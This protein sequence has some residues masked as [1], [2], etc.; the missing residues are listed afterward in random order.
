MSTSAQMPGSTS[1]ASQSRLGAVARFG[2]LIGPMLSMIDSSV[3]NVA[4]PD[5]ATEFKAP[6]DQVQWVVSAYLLALGI[7]LAVTSYL[8]K[9][10]GTLRIYLFS[11]LAFV[12]T[13]AVCAIAPSVDWLIAFRALQ[14]FAGAPLVPL[15][16]GMLFDKSA[17]EK[18]PIGAALVLFLAPSLGPTLGGLLIGSGGWR[19]IF[20]INIP[21]GIFGLLTLVRVPK[22]AGPPTVP[23]T[24]FDPIGF[25]LLALGVTGTLYGASQGTA[26][27]WNSPDSY[28]PL[29]VGVVLLVGYTF[30]ALRRE[31][32]VV[33]LLMIRHGNSALALLLQ[34]LC[35]VVT[36]G[37]IFLI[38]VFTQSL[39]GY[40]A[41][42]T[43]LALL[44]QG[45]VMGLGTALGQVLSKRI[46]LRVLVVVGFA[47]LA[48]SSVFLVL[49]APD[50]PLWVTAI[51]LCGRAIGIGFVTAP[52]LM[53][54]LAPLEDSELADGNTLFNIT[55]RIGGSV[56]VSILGSMIATGVG[57]SAV[58]DSFHLVGWIMIAVAVVAAFA[59]LALRPRAQQ[60]AVSPQ[61]LLE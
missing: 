5:I 35:S 34:V 45:I 15:A 7:G 44:P 31:N 33:N 24:R 11:M 13:S 26:D 56:G 43:G 28:L 25:L 4:I 19:W 6:L 50:T 41:L 55:Q 42:E 14:G 18:F 39:Q 47:A 53:S 58:V 54:M 36:F 32:P 48:A 12:V 59:S 23:G 10:F 1:V 30:W 8:A 9:R 22:S 21:V 46:S 57:L 3:V 61:N 38:P 40:S 20:L 49:I 16:M 17:R 27:G 60:A 51:M 37:T 29:G 52:L 2:L